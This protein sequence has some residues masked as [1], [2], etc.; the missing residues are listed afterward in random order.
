MKHSGAGAQELWACPET[1]FRAGQQRVALLSVTILR[2][3]RLG[4][5]L[6]DLEGKLRII[7]QGMGTG[8]DVRSLPQFI[9]EQRKFGN[10]MLKLL[11][12]SLYWLLVFLPALVCAHRH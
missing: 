2:L 9:V 3:G 8:I 11:R 4:Q 6:T 1:C 7:A 10:E 5:A 12:P